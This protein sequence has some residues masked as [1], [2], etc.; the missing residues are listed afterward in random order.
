MAMKDLLFLLCISFLPLSI[1]FSQGSISPENLEKA[2]KKAEREARN[3]SKSNYQVHN[4]EKDLEFLIREYYEYKYTENDQGV[5]LYLVPLL[6]SREK[7]LEKAIEVAFE[8]SKHNT[9]GVMQLYFYSWINVDDRT[10]QEQKDLLTKA[11]EIAELSISEMIQN[12]DP[13]KTYIFYK[14][15]KKD[16][17]LELRVVYDQELLKELCRKEII[18]SL[19]SKTAFQ[20]KDIYQLLV[21]EK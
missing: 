14:K 16:F 4:N 17:R 13:L 15:L 5:R 3:Y 6:M 1:C 8:K 21:F 12:T 7:S 20:G 11:A 10:T 19:S 18:A 2:A 9:L